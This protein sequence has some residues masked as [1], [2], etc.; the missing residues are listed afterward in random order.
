MADNDDEISIDIS[1]ITSIFKGKPNADKSGKAR[2][3]EQAKAS[4]PAHNRSEPAEKSQDAEEDISVDLSKIKNLF[5]PKEGRAEGRSA[6]KKREADEDSN[7]ISL[8][9]GKVKN[10]FSK[11]NPNLLILLLILIPL[12][13]G[14]FIRVQTIEL[15]ATDE[16]AKATVYDYYRNLMMNDINQQYPTLPQAKKTELLNTEFEKFVKEQSAMLEPNI[17]E[18]STMFKQEFKDDEGDNYLPDIDTYYW[19]RFI[20]NLDQKGHLGDEVINGEQFD[21]HFL[22]PFGRTISKGEFFHIYLGYYFYRAVKLFDS[23]IVPMVAFAYLPVFLFALSV[24]F[25][26]FITRRIAGNTGGFFAALLFSVVPFLVTKS[27]VGYADTDIQ[28]VFF[29]LLIAFLFLEAFEAKKLLKSVIFGVLAGLAAGLFSFTWMGWWYIFDF[30]V[31][32]TG[33]YLLYYLYL[34]RKRLSEQTIKKAAFRLAIPI[35]IFA[36]STAVFVGLLTGPE[37]ILLVIKGPLSFRGI[38]DVATL[39]IWPN[40]YTTVAEQNVVPLSNLISNIGGNFLFAL[41]VLGIALTLTKKDKHGHIDMKYPL[42]LSIWF[43]S[44]LY[45]S[46]KG[47][48]FILIIVPAFSIGFGTFVGI[49]NQHISRFIEKEFSIKKAWGTAILVV[50]FGLI[51]IPSLINSYAITTSEVPDISDAWVRSL[52]MIKENAS[53]EAVINSWWDYGHWFKHWAD[54][55]VTFD[56]TSQNTPR[57]HWI[58]RMLLTDDED[59][60]VSL[61]RMMDC[62]ADQTAFALINEKLD[63]EMKSVALL[64]EVIILDEQDA[65]ELLE[66]SGFGQEEAEEIVSLTHCEPPDNYLITS[67]DMVQKSG[68]WAH[69]GSWNFTKSDM[70]LRI[71]SLGPAEGKAL[72]AE[73]YDIPD[74]QL[75]KYYYDIK[76]QDPNNWIA[77]W[78]GYASSPAGCTNSSDLLL[79]SDGLKFNISSGEMY[80]DSAAGGRIY[81]ARYSYV[82]ENGDFRIA[83]SNTSIITSS[84]GQQLGASLIKIGE[85]YYT[86]LMS[87]EI[88]GSMFNRLFYYNGYG[89][90]HFDLFYS[91]RD[92]RGT[93]IYVWKVDWEGK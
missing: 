26:F 76:N 77:D 39:D 75:D 34:N 12:A 79:C 2:D 3:V 30:L 81:P 35:L 41:S 78:P 63:D 38:K 72:L 9:F 62:G 15:H 67:E 29:P 36:V 59:E 87:P 69:F 51:L 54:T 86:I 37:T 58:G 66:E 50:L 24:V 33:I 43:I 74:A 5:K 45:A 71:K 49:A 90:N 46:T 19:M 82:D 10:F 70:V 44:T 8:D 28:V 14:V 65:K 42:L 1:K 16:W 91:D 88:V 57:A 25:I 40:V 89:L 20:E 4:E 6:A 32:A 93:K 64:K 60:A 27:G 13:L 22:Y 47:M 17:K 31:G 11:I 7:E 18:L 84:N 61:L 80:I 52:Q 85:S 53:D 92:V 48:R 73:R 21:N 23:G 56:G 55:P 68:V 83:T